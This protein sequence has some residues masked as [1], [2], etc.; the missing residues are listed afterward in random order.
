MCIIMGGPGLKSFMKILR[1][2]SWCETTVA[3]RTGISRLSKQM[4]ILT[5]RDS[6]DNVQAGHGCKFGAFQTH[7]LG[8]RHNR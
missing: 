4:K 7:N 2:V 3:I 8:V 6:G 1:L 5:Y